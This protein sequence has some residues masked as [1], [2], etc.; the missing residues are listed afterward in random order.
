MQD[1][2]SVYQ[3]IREFLN[4]PFNMKNPSQLKDL[5]KT[6]NELDGKYAK[7]VKHIC[8]ISSTEV[9]GSYLLHLKIP[10]QSRPGTYYDVVIQFFTTDTSVENADSLEPYLLQFFSNSPSFI[11]K[12]A[13]L[14]KMHGYLIEAFQSKLN[15]EYGEK[16]PEKTNKEGILS[17]DKSL[18]FAC[19]YIVENQLTLLSK[20]RLKRLRQVPLKKLI[21]KVASSDDINPQTVHE[22]ETELKEELNKDKKSAFDFIKKRLTAKPHTAKVGKVSKKVPI[23]GTSKGFKSHTIKKKSKILPSFSTKK[24]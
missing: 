6:K 11:Y 23:F 17:F 14:Y 9:A 5:Q 12:Y 22:V 21:S 8:F 24:K 15:Q 2:G 1:T 19:K 4:R 18:Y 20:S 3:T 7:C 16:Y 13:A 10:S